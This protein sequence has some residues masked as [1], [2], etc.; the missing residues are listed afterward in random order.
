MFPVNP[1]SPTDFVIMQREIDFTPSAG[2][3]LYQPIYGEIGI[4]VYDGRFTATM[5]DAIA[6]TDDNVMESLLKD[7]WVEVKK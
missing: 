6:P 2:L 1:K 5:K 3:I 4:V 7:G